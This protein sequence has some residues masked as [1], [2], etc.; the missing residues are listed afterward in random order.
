MS[1]L[2]PAILRKKEKP[3]QELKYHRYEGKQPVLSIVPPLTTPADRIRTLMAGEEL[4]HVQEMAARCHLPD[5]DLTYLVHNDFVE[6]TVYQLLAIAAA[7]NVSVLWLL[8]YYTDP[9]N[10][11]TDRELILKI[12]KRN[13]LE[14][15]EREEKRSDFVNQLIR[16]VRLHRLHRVEMD[17]CMIASDFLREERLPLTQEA[18]RKTEGKPIYVEWHLDDGVKTEPG[19]YDSKTDSIIT[20]R[21][22]T[23]VQALDDN[24]KVFLCA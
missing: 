7:Y 18:I 13:S 4:H 19:I 11:T 21:E 24:C 17:I 2:L 9:G 3:G 10:M 20:A 16:K 1:I 5:D 8:G 14:Q 22:T 6:P 15:Q 12:S 23:K